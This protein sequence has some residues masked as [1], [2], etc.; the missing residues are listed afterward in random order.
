MSRNITA[1]D[2]VVMY[3][4]SL[5]PGAGVDLCWGVAAEAFTSSVDGDNNNVAAGYPFLNVIK[6]KTG[7][8]LKFEFNH[9]LAQLN[10]QIDADIDEVADDGKTKIYVR[11]VTFNGF[12]MR[13]SL[14]LNSNTTDG[15]IWYDISGTGRF[16]ME[17]PTAWKA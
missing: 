6:P 16:T 13:G 17:G 4:S 7:D 9:A 2:P 5:T 11:S 10:V 14:N 3:S 8:H 1:G 12:S 15:P